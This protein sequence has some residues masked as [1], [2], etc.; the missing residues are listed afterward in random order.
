ML[1]RSYGS[2]NIDQLPFTIKKELVINH[3]YKDV[4]NNHKRIFESVSCFQK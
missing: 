4:I 1:M 2:Y 3:L